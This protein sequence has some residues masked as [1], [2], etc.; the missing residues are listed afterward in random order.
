VETQKKFVL[1][2]VHKYWN[3]RIIQKK[4]EAGT[5]ERLRSARESVQIVGCR[6]EK[7][8]DALKLIAFSI[9]NPS[10]SWEKG[11]AREGRNVRF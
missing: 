7:R 2:F 8:N 3:E 6:G 11:R 1:N 10:P 4:A 9:S 5:F